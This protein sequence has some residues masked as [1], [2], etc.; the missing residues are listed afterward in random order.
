MASAAP[1]L[2]GVRH[3]SPGAAWHLRQWLDRLRPTAVLIEELSDAEDRLP[4]IVGPGTRLPIAVLA[5]TTELPVRTLLTPLARYSPEYVA[6]QWARAHGVA[7][8][9][10][11]L[12]AAIFLA[13]PPRGV[14]AAEL[15]PETADEAPATVSFYERFATASG[16]PDHES[17]WE[18]HFEHNQT[19]DAYRESALAYG[20]GLR[21]W[22]AAEALTD[23]NDLVREA[24]MRRCLAETI[25]AGHAPE[26][27]AV[28]V[29]AYHAPVLTFEQPPM[30]DAEL[31]RL[32]TVPARLTLMPYSYFRLS[33]QSGYGAGNR[34][35][36]YFELMYEQLERGDLDGLA[37]RYL[38]GIAHHVRASGT[39]RSVAEAIEGT[40]LATALAALHGG[41]A[42]T[43]SDLQ[44]AAITCIGRGERST[45]AEAMAHL[46]VGTALGELPEG[47]SQTSIQDDFARELKRL[48]LEPY[49]SPVA[50]DLALDLRENRR[51]QSEA[52]AFLDLQ[53]SRFLHRLHALD[54]CFAKPRATRQEEATWAEAWV[55]QWTPE[56]EI[57]LVEATLRGETIELATAFAIRTRLAEATSVGAAAELV[58][59]AGLCGM[60]AA[61]AE[62][63]ATVQ[64]LATDAG[65]VPELGRAAAALSAVIRYGDVR[66][67]EATPLVPL[68]AQVFLRGALLLV[69]AAGCDA[70]AATELLTA[71]HQLNRVA[72]D[73]DQT[74]DE[75]QWL[76]ALNE[77]SDRDDRNPLLSG[78][79][80]A[81]LLE[82]GAMPAER[83]AR[84][85]SRRLSPGIPADLGAGWFEG[86]AQRNRYALL[87]RLDLWR[88]LAAYIASLDDPQFRRALVF[89]RRAFG[90]F[91]PSERAQV[92]ENL[93]EV[94][95]VS[96]ATASEALAAPLNDQEQAKLKALSDFDF[97]DL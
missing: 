36:A 95:G 86:L 55:L 71:M 84:E 24:Y 31:A 7:C 20:A 19:P 94:W 27:I 91:S 78:Y 25:A 43:L 21:E 30:S 8:R 23:P 83:L 46:E 28:I 40:R 17:W 54:N 12:P 44:A 52:A 77:L 73:H 79:A 60:P 62:A 26:R 66:Q 13:L 22:Q 92:A 72:L 32:P 6:M 35:P 39:P 51:V 41:N 64:R 81:I 96:A 75:G 29:G 16:E 33:S 49:R 47:V 65:A 85:V 58:Q 37:P 87:S 59:T 80:A 76:A 69:G 61:L 2:F 50:R 56:A 38:S 18:R 9:F 89:L 68:L 10:I 74:V 34:A 63:G 97:T 67:V 93:G 48:K 5:Y 90:A 3:L 82:R 1:Q 88:H 70:A 45:V 53:R 57:Q 42:A 4:Y 15:V 14:S 11:D